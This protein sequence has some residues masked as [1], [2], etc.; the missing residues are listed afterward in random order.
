[1]L[2]WLKRSGSRRSSISTILV[3]APNEV[4]VASLQLACPSIRDN[5]EGNLLSL[6]K[7]LHPSAL[8]RPDMHKD[9]A[10]AFIRLDE[11]VARV[12]IEPL[13]RA[14]H[15]SLFLQKW[16]ALHLPNGLACNSWSAFDRPRGGGGGMNGGDAGPGAGAGAGADAAGDGFGNCL[17]GIFTSTRLPR[18]SSRIGALIF[19]WAWVT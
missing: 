5:V 9:V 7:D 19:M 2:V 4:Q 14:L 6:I 13:H 3:C 8:N 16:L 18:R 17:A 10:P 11:A 1:L 15:V 12:R